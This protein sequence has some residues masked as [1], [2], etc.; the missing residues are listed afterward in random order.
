MPFSYNKLWFKLIEQ[1]MTKEALRIKIKASPATISKMG[2]D[3]NVHLD[4][5]DRICTELKCAPS[6][7]LEYVPLKEER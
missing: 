1:K 6:D 5:I 7:I 2:R 3:E 4:V